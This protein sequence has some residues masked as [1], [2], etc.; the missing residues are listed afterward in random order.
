MIAVTSYNINDVDNNMFDKQH[1]YMIEM[2]LKSRLTDIINCYDDNI[3]DKY[4]QI[5]NLT[6]KECRDLLSLMHYKIIRDFLLN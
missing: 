4:V 3:I 5:I 1:L 6:V 2:M